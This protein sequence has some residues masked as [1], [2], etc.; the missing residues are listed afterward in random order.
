MVQQAPR[1]FVS[2]LS[3][4]VTSKLVFLLESKAP[5]FPAV[6]WPAL[7]AALSLNALFGKQTAAKTLAY[8]FLVIGILHLL[9]PLVGRFQSLGGVATTVLWGALA[10]GTAIY[11]LKSKAV[12]AFYA[13]P[14]E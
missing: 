10:I 9:A 4:V 6:L 14:I 5:L 1:P 8:V 12:K 3:L 13:G 2:L 11:I 7:L